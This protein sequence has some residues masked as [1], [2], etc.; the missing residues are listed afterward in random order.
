MTEEPKVHT[1][2]HMPV[3]MD[4]TLRG[5]AFYNKCN[6]GEIIHQAIQEYTCPTKKEE[7]AALENDKFNQQLDRDIQRD[8]ERL[9]RPSDELPPRREEAYVPRDRVMRSLHLSSADFNKA[10]DCARKTGLSRQIIFKDM[11]QKYLDK[12][13]RP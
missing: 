1:E 13:P 7:L 3:A 2:M 5:L 11:I 4:D 9:G 12:H 10:A 6:P 8:I